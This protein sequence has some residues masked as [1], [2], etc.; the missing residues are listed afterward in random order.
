MEMHIRKKRDG[1]EE[2]KER[3][4]NGR[5]TNKTSNNSPTVRGSG[6]GTKTKRHIPLAVAKMRDEKKGQGLGPSYAEPLCL[7]I[8]AN[9]DTMDA[10]EEPDDGGTAATDERRREVLRL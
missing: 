8:R 3:G 10:N 9:G 1:E 2:K 5:E 4:M 7:R 6:R